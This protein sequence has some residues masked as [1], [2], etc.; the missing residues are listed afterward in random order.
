M[1]NHLKFLMVDLNGAN[2]MDFSDLE[3]PVTKSFCVTQEMIDNCDIDESVT[4]D[5]ISFPKLLSVAPTRDPQKVPTDNRRTDKTEINSTNQSVNQTNCATDDA[6]N[7]G[8]SNR[9]EDQI[10]GEFVVAMLKKMTP[11]EKKRTKKEIM[12]ILL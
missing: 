7:S 4:L 9:C 11:E 10:F 12:N 1:A 2:E 3:K 6:N 5:S 8:T